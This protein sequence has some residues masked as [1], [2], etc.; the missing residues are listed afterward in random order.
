MPSSSCCQWHPYTRTDPPRKWHDNKS[1]F[2]T[3]LWIFSCFYFCSYCPNINQNIAIVAHTP[4]TG[5][6][7]TARLLPSSPFLLVA[8]LVFVLVA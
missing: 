2:Q 3:K 8:V 5:Q 6:E 4:P 7:L 1:S